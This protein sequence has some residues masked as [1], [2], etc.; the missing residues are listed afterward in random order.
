MK[1][2]PLP[3]QSANVWVASNIRIGGTETLQ[4]DVRVISA[5]NVDL[6]EEVRRGNF[7]EDLFYRLNVIQLK[8][9][10]LRQCKGDTPLLVEYFIRKLDASK[11]GQLMRT[12]GGRGRVQVG[13][14]FF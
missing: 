12:C 5:T 14:M 4:V 3:A 11:G 10:P 1:K 7:R 13:A 9:P 8:L 6:Q 2:G